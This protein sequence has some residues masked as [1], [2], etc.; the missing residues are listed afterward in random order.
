MNLLCIYFVF[1]CSCSEQHKTGC[2][3]LWNKVQ[4]WQGLQQ[5]VA[6]KNNRTMKF[7]T[8]FSFIWVRTCLID[9]TTYLYFPQQF[10]I[11][12]LLILQ[13]EYCVLLYFTFQICDMIKGMSR[14]SAMLGRHF[15]G[16]IGFPVYSSIMSFVTFSCF[17]VFLMFFSVFMLF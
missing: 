14:M 6:F 10:Q 15:T 12:T 2:I 5:N 17:L 9:H 11:C 7:R 1:Q 16:L 3:Y 4:F 13:I 8:R